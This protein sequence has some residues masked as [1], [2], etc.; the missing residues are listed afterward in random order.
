MSNPESETF[1]E[2][3]GQLK[4]S[5]TITGEGDEQLQ[6]T[7]DPNPEKEDIIQPPQIKPKFY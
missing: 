7:D 1:G 5:I 2:V 4:L 3:T 6:I